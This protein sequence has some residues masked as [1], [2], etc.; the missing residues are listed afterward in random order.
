MAGEWLVAWRDRQIAEEI[1]W[2][3]IS[4]GTLG[5]SILTSCKRNS[6]EEPGIG[7]LRVTFDSSLSGKMQAKSIDDTD[8]S[9][10]LL[11]PGCQ[12]MEIKSSAPVP[13]WLAHALSESHVYKRSFS[14]CG[15]AYKMT[16]GTV[17][18]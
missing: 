13:L 5:P 17:L 4:H 12:V 10:A 6:Y 16:K 3:M 11:D 15:T 8:G 2:F 9:F 14:K 1:R 7:D 18:C